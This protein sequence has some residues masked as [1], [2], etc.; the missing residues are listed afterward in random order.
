MK[1]TTPMKSAKQEIRERIEEIIHLRLVGAQQDHIRQY[2]SDNGW[3]LSARQVEKYILRADRLPIAEQKME[4]KWMMGYHLARRDHLYGKAMDAGKLQT[5]LNILNSDAKLRGLYPDKDTT[6]LRKMVKDQSRQIAEL[7]DRL[8][9]YQQHQS[10]PPEILQPAP[11]PIHLQY[12]RPVEL[13]D[14]DAHTPG[15]PI[16]TLAG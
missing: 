13:V 5:A 15:L 4:R 6:R 1:S 7:D 12:S 8:R 11:E 14:R 9:D 10:S 3:G 2:A 16:C